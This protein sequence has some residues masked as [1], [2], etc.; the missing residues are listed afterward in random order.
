MVARGSTNLSKG[1]SK[2]ITMGRRSY[3]RSFPDLI[4][5]FRELRL[6]FPT[7]LDLT[8]T[9][10]CIGILFQPLPKCPMRFDFV[11]TVQPHVVLI[12]LGCR[13]VIQSTAFGRTV[14][15]TPHPLRGDE[16]IASGPSADSNRQ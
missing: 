2:S 4:D 5:L 9:F 13:P 16:L 10:D 6:M 15:F 14:F 7:G 3:T 8:Q 1:A 11:Q 12:F